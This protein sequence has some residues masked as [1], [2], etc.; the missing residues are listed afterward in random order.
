MNELGIPMQPHY[1]TQVRKND[2]DK[3]DY[4]IGMDKWNYK[5]MMRIFGSDPDGKVSL[6]LEF[7][8]SNRD[9]ADPW[10]TGNFEETYEDILEGC[11]ALLE[12][13]RRQGVAGSW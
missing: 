13:I 9:I 10:Y 6:L 11:E 8:G 1:A 7:A 4:I 2:Y 5:N 3:F 12:S